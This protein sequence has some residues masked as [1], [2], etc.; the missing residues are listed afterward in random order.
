MAD[1]NASVCKY[2]GLPDKWC[3]DDTCGGSVPWSAAASIEL[4]CGVGGDDWDF[5]DTSVMNA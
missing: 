4:P 5:P 3:R 2:V 1:V